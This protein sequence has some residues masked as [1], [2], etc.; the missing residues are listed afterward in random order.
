MARKDISYYRKRL[1]KLR[2]KIENVEIKI[3]KYFEDSFQKCTNLEFTEEALETFRSVIGRSENAAMEVNHHM[4][5][6][7]ETLQNFLYKW[8]T[9]R[10]IDKKTM[11][12]AKRLHH[13]HVQFK[14]YVEEIPPEMIPGVTDIIM[15]KRWRGY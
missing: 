6:N 5:K 3:E 13:E 2:L 8:E 4:V 14:N 7:I 1:S 10:N 15:Q 9:S 11:K 12:L